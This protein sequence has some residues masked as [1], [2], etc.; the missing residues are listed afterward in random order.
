MPPGIFLCGTRDVADD[1]STREARA[2]AAALVDAA[3]QLELL[4]GGDRS[5]RGR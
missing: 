3:E 5:I 4:V 1:L 2:L